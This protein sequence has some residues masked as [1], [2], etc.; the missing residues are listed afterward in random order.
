M[1]NEEQ[2]RENLIIHIEGLQAVLIKRNARIAEL[3]AKLA[4]PE[5]INN[6][7][8]K[9]AYRQG[10]KDCASKMMDAT[11]DTAL[12]LKEIR[13]DAFEIYLEGDNL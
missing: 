11:K 5:L 13:K 8:V 7:A 2:N 12:L 6:T 9:R 3:E 10:F 1:T 4:S